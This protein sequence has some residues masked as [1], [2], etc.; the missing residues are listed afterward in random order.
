MIFLLKTAGRDEVHH[1]REKYT[2][3]CQAK[4]C[5]MIVS[6]F[7]R[8]LLFVLC[9]GKICMAQRIDAGTDRQTDRLRGCSFSAADHTHDASQQSLSSW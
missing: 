9:F 4:A 8:C 1:R 2:F 5:I 3:I 6:S 7:L